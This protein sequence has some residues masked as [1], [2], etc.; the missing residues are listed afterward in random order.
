MPQLNYV[1]HYWS[2]AQNELFHYTSLYLHSNSNVVIPLTIAE[3]A[4]FLQ[5]VRLYNHF[6]VYAHYI[7]ECEPC[8]KN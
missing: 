7:T 3:H 5:R 4:K 6:I 2:S 1:N 8:Y